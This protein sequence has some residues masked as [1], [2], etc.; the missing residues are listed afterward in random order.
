MRRSQWA[1]RRWSPIAAGR[2]Q[3]AAPNLGLHVV[4]S[5]R[6]RTM[7]AIPAPP[8]NG[9]HLGALGAIPAPPHNGTMG[10]ISAPPHRGCQN[11]WLSNRFRTEAAKTIGSQWFSHRGYQNHWLQIMSNKK[12]FNLKKSQKQ[13]LKLRMLSDELPP[14]RET[15]IASCRKFPFPNLDLLDFVCVLL[16]VFG[17]FWEVW[18]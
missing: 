15:D 7:G 11:H 9:C 10:A 16:D 1:G 17:G 12:H 4:P 2:R 14:G 5:R 3:P 13:K 6:P 8:H 18:S